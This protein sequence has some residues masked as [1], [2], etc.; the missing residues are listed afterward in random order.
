MQKRCVMFF[1]FLAILGGSMLSIMMRLSEGRVQ[2]KTS[3]LAVNYVA[4]LF[5]CGFYMGFDLSA[6]AEGSGFSLFLGTVTG[7]FYVLS[8][9]VMQA[10]IRKNGVI[11]PSVFSR[12]GGLLVPLFAAVLFFGEQPTVLQIIG[13]VIAVFSIVAINAGGN[14][15]SVTSI[16]SLLLLLLLDGCATTMSTVYEKLG[17][18]QLG[19][20]F[21]FYTFATALVICI[22]LILRNKERLGF[23]EILFGLGIGIPNFYSAKFMLAALKTV[24]AVIVYPVCSVGTILVVTT[25]GVLLFKERLEKRQW[26]ALAMILVALVLLNI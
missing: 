16:A 14:R 3:M 2:S 17:N 1:L 18:S 15:S 19:T 11:L 5:L 24:P 4:C 25:A 8:L 23:R 13:S 12:L 10:N 7:V 6:R 9:L 22:A 20:H 21:L 26:A